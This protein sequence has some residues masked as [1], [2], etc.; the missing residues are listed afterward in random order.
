MHV[1]PILGQLQMQSAKVVASTRRAALSGILVCSLEVTLTYK[2]GQV[3]ILD[4]PSTVSTGNKHDQ[5]RKEAP[6]TQL[7]LA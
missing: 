5:K 3:S 4:F 2:K 1:L 7:H 6:E